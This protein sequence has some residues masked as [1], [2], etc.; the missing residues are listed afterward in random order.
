MGAAM[1]N[2]NA[3]GLGP[4]GQSLRDR[5]AV[6]KIESKPL[7]LLQDSI[8]SLQQ[9]RSLARALAQMKRREAM[10]KAPRVKKPRKHKKHC[11]CPECCRCKGM[12]CARKNPKA[13]SSNV[14]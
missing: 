2:S 4:R 6:E 5:V 14:Y 13:R 7:D 1:S 10:P 11:P 8:T 12:T 3:I 9:E